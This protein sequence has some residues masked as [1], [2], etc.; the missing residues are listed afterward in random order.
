MLVSTLQITQCHN[1]GD[2]NMNL[3]RCG[4]LRSYTLRTQIALTM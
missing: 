1:T 4:N 2:L 3:D